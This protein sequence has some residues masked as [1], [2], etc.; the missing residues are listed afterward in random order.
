MPNRP[1]SNAARWAAFALS[2]W[3]L[4]SCAAGPLSPTR[5]G[6]GPPPVEGRARRAAP[7]GFAGLADG[8]RPSVVHVSTRNPGVRARRGGLSTD[9]REFFDRMFENRDAAGPAETA[10]GERPSFGGG[11]GEGGTGT[12]FLIGARGEILTNHHVVEGA[13]EIRV[14]LYGGEWRQASLVGADPLT[15]L[16]L[17]RIHSKKP[18]PG[19]RLGD[20]A[21]AR[22]G[23]WVLAIGNPFGLEETVTAGILSA[24]GRALE[25][26]I[27]SGYLQTDAPIHRG[28]SGGPLLNLRGEVIGVNTAVVSGTPGIGFAIPINL[29]RRLL[30]DLRA[31]GRVRRGWIGVSIQEMDPELA[32][33]F[34][35][36]RAGK[37]GVL[38]ARVREGGPAGRAGLRAGDVILSL[39]GLPLRGSQDFGRALARA[40][41]G[42]PT[43]LQVFRGGE[44][45]VIPVMVRELRESRTTSKIGPSKPA[46]PAHPPFGLDLRPLSPSMASRLGLEDPAGLIVAAVDSGSAADRA[47]VRR[48]DIVRSIGLQAVRSEKGMREILQGLK[49]GETLLL[50]QRGDQRIFLLLK[51]APRPALQS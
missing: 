9:L 41:I 21:G 48:G 5:A 10:A 19:A 25:G 24:K 31:H 43:P 51:I 4:G 32:R 14:R 30:P 28:N 36:P 44:S 1:M 29:V 13:A 49:G 15:D 20:S 33:Y 47:G 40:G 42:A 22:V 18:L 2:G 3:V 11:G 50:I 46:K 27:F 39:G 17:L 45:L 26:A 7:P 38:I 37:G 35:L 12:G 23:D 6:Q 34:R 16:A 8:L